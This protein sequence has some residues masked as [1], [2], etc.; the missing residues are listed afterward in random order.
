M[1][2]NLAA[3]A[4]A[5]LLSVGT[6]AS[7]LILPPQIIRP[8]PHAAILSKADV[9]NETS[10]VGSKIEE[11]PMIEATPT[12]IPLPTP[13]KAP[14]VPSP[15]KS[16]PTPT[17]QPKADRPLDDT[18][19]PTPTP[20]P[21]VASVATG[22]E[23]DN[24][25]TTYSG[26]YGVDRELLRKIAQCES[27]FNSNARHLGYGGMY[28]FSEESWRSARGAMGLDTNP[29]LRFHAEE[30]VKTAAYKLSQPN[31]ANAWPSCK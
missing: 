7:S 5:S 4:V 22:V 23:L 17:P 18:I 12:E 15:T 20:V 16:T 30:S 26:Q 13:T 25:F 21:V 29:E 8:V 14:F 11:A 28:Q 3:L 6:F 19:T 9:K 31:G 27:S 10:T 2:E 1:F 24:F